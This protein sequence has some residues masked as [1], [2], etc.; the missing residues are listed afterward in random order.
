MAHIVS[1]SIDDDLDLA[2]LVSRAGY[3]NRSRFMRDAAQHYA[4]A[5]ERGDLAS[6]PEETSVEGTLVI[7]HQH[8]VERRLPDLRHSDG[9]ELRSSTHACMT[10]SHTCVDT[11]HL[12]GL[13]GSIQQ[14]VAGL[15]RIEG[16]DRVIFVAAP[17]RSSGCC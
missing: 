3:T 8:T 1:V 11:M 5:I 15:R 12:A 2:A 17:T 9:I 14:A 7:Y 4:D 6:L 16:V 13:A 10:G